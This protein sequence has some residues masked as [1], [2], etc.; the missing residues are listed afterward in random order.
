M[1]LLLVQTKLLF[2]ALLALSVASS[3]YSFYTVDTNPTAAFY[4]PLSRMWELGTGCILAIWLHRQAQAP[5]F[6]PP[7]CNAMSMLGIAMVVIAFVKLESNSPFLMLP[8]LG[9]ALVIAGKEGWVNRAILSN[10]SVVYI[11]LIS[12]PLYLWHWP[13]LT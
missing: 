4:S 13:L 1:L 11:G 5:V 10:R 7:W 6:S 12:Y 3:A 8:V 9:T 2:F